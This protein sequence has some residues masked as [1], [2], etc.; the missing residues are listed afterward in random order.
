M[1]NNFFNS[2]LGNINLKP[3]SNSEVL[4]Q[5]LYGEK[6][7]ILNKAKNWVKIRTSYDN[8]IGYIKK[9]K[10]YKKFKPERKISKLKSRIFIKRNKKFFQSN[11]HLYFGSGISILNMSKNFIE[12]DKN[13]W[14]RREDTKDIYYKEKNFIKVLKI[15]LNCKYL[16]GGKSCDGIDCSALI[17]IYFY[18]NRIF[19]PRD[20]K[21]Q[22]KFSKK[23]NGKKLDKGDIIFWKGHV[24]VCLNKSKFIHAYGPKK[25]VII[26]PTKHTINLIYKTANLVIKKISNI[27]NY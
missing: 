3:S 6:F 12:F 5:I 2:S 7:T 23:K 18:Y 25:K 26:M 14:V 1:R 20:S 22:I 11:K 9:N 16:W 4:S 24:G 27:K 19:F 21:D 8:Y 10:F 15:F 13:K 17:Q